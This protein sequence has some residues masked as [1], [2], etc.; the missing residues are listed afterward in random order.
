MQKSITIKQ[1]YEGIGENLTNHAWKRM[2]SRGVSSAAVEAV[3]DYGRLTY[4]RGAAIYAIG[5][6]EVGR[7]AKQGID[8][9]SFEGIQVVCTTGGK[10]LTVY[11]NRGFRRLR[12]YRR[13]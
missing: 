3:F 4:I 9:S 11:R 5:R 1:N 12:S 7:F 8:L 10:I 2:T 6:K 13:R